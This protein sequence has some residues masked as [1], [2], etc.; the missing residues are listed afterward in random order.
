MWGQWGAF[1]KCSK[2]CGGGTRSRR[3]ACDSPA[4]E[5]GGKPCPGP[6]TQA[7]RCNTKPCAGKSCIVGYNFRQLHTEWSCF[8]IKSYVLYILYAAACADKYPPGNIPCK[9]S[10]ACAKLARTRKCNKKWVQAL[11]RS[12]ANRIPAAHRNRP[13]KAY[14]R[15][16]CKVCRGSY[17][18]SH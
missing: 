6:A 5:N 7:G 14:C 11:P 10:F 17:T 4:P 3:R 18:W 2:P 1:G 8:R 15:K 12:C 16:S 9:K 13:V